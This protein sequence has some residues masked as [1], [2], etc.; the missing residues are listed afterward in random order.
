MTDWL[1]CCILFFIWLVFVSTMWSNLTVFRGLFKPLFS[2][3][4]RSPSHC[5]FRWSCNQAAHTIFTPQP[6][7]FYGGNAGGLKLNLT[8]RP[9]P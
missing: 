5:C 4:A 3:L 9:M 7:T 1:F 6:P 2:E 8:L